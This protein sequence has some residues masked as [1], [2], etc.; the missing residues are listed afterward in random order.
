MI[1]VSADVKIWIAAG[2]TDMRRG[3][4]SLARQVEQ[5]LGRGFRG[6][7]LSFLDHLEREKR[8]TP[9]PEQCPCCGSQ[10]LSHLPPDITET[11]EKVPARHKVTE[12]GARES[13]LPAL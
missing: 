5:H 7:R 3:M 9:A 8:V 6:S 13:L 11:L 4:A 12:T 1:P 2:H 10:E